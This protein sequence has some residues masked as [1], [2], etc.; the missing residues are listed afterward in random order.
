MA[1]LLVIAVRVPCSQPPKYVS[2]STVVVD[3]LSSCFV[4]HPAHYKRL[5][6]QTR[7]FVFVTISSVISEETFAVY[8]PTTYKNWVTSAKT[9][10]T[11]PN[12]YVLHI[13]MCIRINIRKI[14][15][16]TYSIVFLRAVNFLLPHITK[17]TINYVILSSS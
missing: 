8:F 9:L 16:K 3:A 4:I 15:T 12:S 13:Q 11:V 10:S 6:K 14:M 5:R 17:G 7:R 1:L 2:S